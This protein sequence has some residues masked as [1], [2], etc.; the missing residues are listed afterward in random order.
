M[1][2]V[3]FYALIYLS[4]VILWKFAIV[5]IVDKMPCEDLNEKE[6]YTDL[7]PPITP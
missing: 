7:W 5:P 1:K 4:I 6:F 2:K 3:V